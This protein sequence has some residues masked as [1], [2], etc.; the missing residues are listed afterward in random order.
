MLLPLKLLMLVVPSNFLQ[1]QHKL[2]YSITWTFRS[3]LHIFV[4]FVFSITLHTSLFPSKLTF[5]ILSKNMP[6]MPLNL[7]NY[8]PHYSLSMYLPVIRYSSYLLKHGSF[9]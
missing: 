5:C 1:M 7:T 6:L 4:I 2:L 9:E 3:G 8:L